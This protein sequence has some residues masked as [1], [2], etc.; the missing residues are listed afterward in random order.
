M[1]MFFSHPQSLAF[2]EQQLC[3]VASSLYW[4]LAAEPMML[5]VMVA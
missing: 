5:L 1:H 3:I 4:L 2:G